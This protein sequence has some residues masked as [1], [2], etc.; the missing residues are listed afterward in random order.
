MVHEL[1]P[2]T[3]NKRELSRHLRTRGVNTL[4]VGAR[5]FLVLVKGYLLESSPMLQ[6]L[7]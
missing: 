2:I 3:L 7:G 6:T 1:H 4:Q 5:I